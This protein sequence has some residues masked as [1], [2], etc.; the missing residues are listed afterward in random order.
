MLFPR[1]PLSLCC[2]VLGLVF[3]AACSPPLA[4][5]PVERD[6]VPQDVRY[7]IDGES[8]RIYSEADGVRI[9][10][11]SPETRTIFS[12]EKGESR[13]F[14]LDSRIEV[15]GH[16]LTFDCKPDPSKCPTPKPIPSIDFQL[17]SKLS[18][19][20]C[21]GIPDKGLCADPPDKCIQRCCK[22]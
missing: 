5:P 11:T 15:Y 18:T 8:L 14:P 17:E 16:L 12:M 10:E 19:C 3:A 7:E 1:K 6:P 4:T 20:F 9:V 13:L 2:F 21:L 22:R